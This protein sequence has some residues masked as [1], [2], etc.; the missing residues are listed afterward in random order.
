MGDINDNQQC[1]TIMTC[2]VKVVEGDIPPP[3]VDLGNIVNIS[4]L[5][6]KD[7]DVIVNEEGNTFCNL[8]SDS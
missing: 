7:S 2:S 4:L 1:T 5:E 3:D 8:R 6:V